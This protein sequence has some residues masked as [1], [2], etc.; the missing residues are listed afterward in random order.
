MPLSGKVCKAARHLYCKVA[1]DSLEGSWMICRS[2][3]SV[4]WVHA[5][6][7][8][9]QCPALQLFQRLLCL[10]LEARMTQLWWECTASSKG[11]CLKEFKEEG[12]LISCDPKCA[13]VPFLEGTEVPWFQCLYQMG[14]HSPPHQ[15]T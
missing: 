14:G 10:C 2:Q 5:S 4:L 15:V 13:L 9:L 11:L 12:L 8:R 3:A 1:V 6:C 7:I